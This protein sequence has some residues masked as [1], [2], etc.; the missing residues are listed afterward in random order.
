MAGPRGNKDTLCFESIDSNYSVVSIDL[1]V[2]RDQILNVKSLF[3]CPPGGKRPWA[4]L[5]KGLMTTV[6]C[7]P[8]L[9]DLICPSVR[10]PQCSPWVKSADLDWTACWLSCQKSRVKVMEPGRLLGPQTY[11]LSGF[12]AVRKK[13]KTKQSNY[14]S[15]HCH[16]CCL[17]RN[18]S[19]SYSVVFVL[20]LKPRGCCTVI[21][22]SFDLSDNSAPN[23]HFC[24]S[25][26]LFCCFQTN[27]R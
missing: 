3:F 4:F 21:P 12:S 17:Y 23:L 13:T 9:W 10:K 14:N 5:Y 24:I 22:T 16:C 1:I 6:Q 20:L 11:Y 8:P 7:L 18:M 2:A 27:H 25:E 26:S 15:W 19:V